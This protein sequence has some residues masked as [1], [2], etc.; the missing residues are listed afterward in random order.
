MSNVVDSFGARWSDGRGMTT[1]SRLQEWFEDNRGLNVVR[2]YSI[3]DPVSRKKVWLKPKDFKTCEICGTDLYRINS[4]DV[5][6]GLED[7][8]EDV[9]VTQKR[10]L[11]AIDPTGAQHHTCWGLKRCL[12][13]TGSVCK[14]NTIKLRVPNL[15]DILGVDPESEVDKVFWGSINRDYE[16]KV[17]PFLMKWMNRSV[18][19]GNVLEFISDMSKIQDHL[20]FYDSRG[21]DIFTNK[22]MKIIGVQ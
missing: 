20:I 11:V 22:I 1:L 12:K 18:S 16:L 8:H 17:R 19:K 4:K 6:E 10:Q 9:I 5:E 13:R 3:N 14:S 15:E 2:Y 21:G 7:I